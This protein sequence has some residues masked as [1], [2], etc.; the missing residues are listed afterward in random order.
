MVPMI[1]YKYARDYLCSD[2]QETF[3]DVASK[4]NF[5]IDEYNRAMDIFERAH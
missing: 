2:V 4:Y 1:S 3:L 5:G